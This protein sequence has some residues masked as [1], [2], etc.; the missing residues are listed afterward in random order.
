MD[1][2]P[3]HL[4][5]EHGREKDG[6]SEPIVSKKGDPSSVLQGLLPVWYNRRQGKAS[7]SNLY[8]VGAMA[9]SFFEYLLKLWLLHQKQA[10]TQS[11]S[12]FKITLS[13]F[14]QQVT[15]NICQSLPCL[16]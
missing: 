7:T 5:A 12:A 1:I 10:N 6:L 9:D 15:E 8:S 11:T 2:H 16:Q 14:L 3:P 13:I 4:Q